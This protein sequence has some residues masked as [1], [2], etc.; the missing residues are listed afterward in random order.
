M[1]LD[2]FF[3][4]RDSAK[5][6]P[7]GMF[8]I[9]HIISS[10]IFILVVVI[11]VCLTVK[12]SEYAINKLIRVFAIIFALLEIGKIIYN[13]SY[14][15]TYV[16]AWVPLSYCSIFIYSLLLA[17]FGKGK[18]RTVGYT[19][20][21][22]AIYAGLFFMI[23]P[24]TSL[25]LHPI[26]HFL[27]VYSLLY[28][29]S[30]IFVGTLVIIKGFVKPNGTNFLYYVLYLLIFSVISIIINSICGSNLMFYTQPYNMPIEMVVSIYKLSPVL[31]TAFIFIA[32]TALY[33]LFILTYKIIKFI[34]EKKK[35]AI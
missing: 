17:G 23:F 32:Y 4:P 11:S 31:Y 29:S 3:A 33:L 15:Y 9:G 24:T 21:A 34:K 18:I 16:D 22:V 19:F 14:G 13:F 7:C 10:I 6:P 27:S 25:M 35:N 30:M 1:L 28:H 2:M 5:Y 8:T 12:M 20:L 26:Y